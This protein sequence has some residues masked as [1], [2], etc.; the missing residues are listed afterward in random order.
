VGGIRVA[1]VE[2]HDTLHARWP[3][4]R[5]SACSARTRRVRPLD[6]GSVTADERTARLEL[7]ARQGNWR[8]SAGHADTA[9]T[10]SGRRRAHDS[11]QP[12]PTGPEDKAL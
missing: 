7:R 10:Q 1:T 11:R 2:N 12:R 4:H 8:A 3:S 9:R 5:G 6:T